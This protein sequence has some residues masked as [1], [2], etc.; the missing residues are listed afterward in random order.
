[1]L[2]RFIHRSRKRAA[3]NYIFLI[4]SHAAAVTMHFI[5]CRYTFDKPRMRCILHDPNSDELRVML[6]D[7]KVQKSGLSDELQL[8]MNSEGLTMGTFD[9]T[10]DYGHFPAEQVRAGGRQHDWQIVVIQDVVAIHTYDMQDIVVVVVFAILLLA[11]L[12]VALMQLATSIVPY[13][14]CGSWTSIFQQPHDQS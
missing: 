12:A 8:V 4:F 5:L 2:Q 11:M 3:N 10:V 14:V 1:M 7:E 13:H 9:V 6:L